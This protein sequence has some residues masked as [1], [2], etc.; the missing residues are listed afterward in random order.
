MLMPLGFP[1]REEHSSAPRVL[2]LV[3]GG[4]RE[5][6]T[7]LCCFNLLLLPGKRDYLDVHIAR[8]LNHVDLFMGADSNQ[9][10]EVSGVS[11]IFYLTLL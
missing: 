10:G 2:V 9:S 6:Q 7:H 3:P 5:S 8:S 4:Q 1:R 11:V